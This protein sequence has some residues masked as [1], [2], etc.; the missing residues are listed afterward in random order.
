M[1]V[2]FVYL[3]D[4]AIDDPKSYQ[5]IVLNNRDELFDRPTLP[6]A[7]KD[8]ILCGRDQADPYGGTW[9]GMTR[10]GRLGNILAV[11]EN[12]TDEI[13]CAITRGKIVYE[14]LKSE[15]PP[16]SYLAE[17]LSKEA[18]QYNGFNVILFDRLFNE[19]IERK[20]YFGFQF[21]NRY[22]S[23]TAVFGPGVYGFGNSAL[24]KP[25]KK[26]TYGLRLFEEKLKILDDENVNEQ[27]LMKQFL[28]ILID[29][30]SHHPDEQL[31]SQKEQDKENCKLMSQLFYKLPEPLRYGTR[32]HTIVLVN[33]VGRCTYFE[34]SRKQLTSV[35][36]VTWDDTTHYFDLDDL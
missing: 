6:P 21:S 34:R 5:L 2:T 29:Q 33:G 11:L 17:Q 32:S 27:E 26:I 16:E 13:P 3:N 14:Y 4:K 35:S 8:G 18:Q 25:F 12:P 30:T 1:C 23:A 15:M 24:G 36:D 7:W 31:I 10:N 19:E 22:D 28:D 20:T 9:L